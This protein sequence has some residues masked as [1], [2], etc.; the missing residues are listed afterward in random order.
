MSERPLIFRN[1]SFSLVWLS[2]VFSQSGTRMYQIVIMWW[3]L[4]HVPAEEA[5]TKTAIFLILCALPPILLMKVIGRIIEGAKS[6]TVFV[7][8]EILAS[9]VIATVGA[10][11]YTDQLTLTA[12][13]ISG[14]LGACCQSFVD[15]TLPKSV[16]E[17]VEPNDV[18]KAVAFETSTQS[19]ANFGGAVFGAM[20]IGWLGFLG[21]VVLNFASYLLSALLTSMATFKAK[22]AASDAARHPERSEGSAPADGGPSGWA[23]LNDLPFIKRILLVFAVA[24]FFITPLFLA[25]PIYTKNVL[26]ETAVGL[27]TF[28][29]AM[30]C[31]LILG[32]MISDRVPERWNLVSIAGSCL[33]IFSIC[34]F[35]PGLIAAS[36]LFG[37]ALF[38]AGFVMGINNVKF[39]TL[40]QKTVPDDRKGRFFSLM[41]AMLTFTFPVSFLLFGILADHMSVQAIML[42]QGTGLLLLSG[43]LFS[44]AK[45]IGVE[46]AVS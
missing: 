30:W 19:F 11:M 21:C 2:Q 39:V 23:I 41:Q 20:I 16:P 7:T 42:I 14:F 24:N 31:G 38:T 5:G 46:N 35:L 32:A 18:E 25:L 8:A 29:A 33:G 10:L 13:Y 1:R 4:N 22:A 3:I 34:L 6:K 40:F 36:V 43:Y 37:S 9:T 44:S 15:P 26:S 45:E 27:A 12:L 28:E 17:L